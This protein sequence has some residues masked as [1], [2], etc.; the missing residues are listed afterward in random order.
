VVNDKE[1]LIAMLTR[2]RNIRLSSE[3]QDEIDRIMSTR[4][5]YGAAK[6]SEKIQIHV[7]QEFGFTGS[8]IKDGLNFLRSAQSLYPNDPEISDIAYYIKYNRSYQGSLREGD[9]IP[10]IQ[11]YTTDKQPIS[12]VKYYQ[13]NCHIEPNISIGNERALVVLA[14][15]IT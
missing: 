10:D 13:Q 15:S 11:L 8:K 4:G 2:E 5:V 7:V 12:L 9:D 6:L 3:T 14:G 1:S